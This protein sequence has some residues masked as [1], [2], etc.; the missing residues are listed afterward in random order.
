V[1]HSAAALLPALLLS[2]CALGPDYARPDIPVSATWRSPADSEASLGAIEWWQLFRD[3]ALQGLIRSA[4]DENKDVRLAVA[5]VLES[6]AQLGATRAAQFPQIDGKASYRNE[7]ASRVSFPPL[8]D[9]L[10]TEQEFFK[11]SLDLSFEIDLWGRLRRATEAARAELLASEEARRN[12]IVT[13]VSD[14]AQAYFT[15]LDLDRELEIARQTLVSRRESLR[16]VRLR[17]E[18][19]ITSELDLRRAEGEVAGASAQIPDLERQIAQSENRIS[20]LLGRNPGPVPRGASLT[21]QPLLPEV[22]AGLPSALLERRPDLRQAEH[23]LV[24]ANARIGEAK[25]AFFPQLMLTGAFGVESIALSDLFTG[26]AKIWQFGPRVTIPIFN[27]GR[28]SSNLRA[29]KARQ[30]QALIQYGQ[31]IQQAFREVEDALVTHRKLREIRPDREVLVASARRSLALAELRYKDGLAS[32]LDVLDA[33]R[34][35][36]AAEI[37]LTR[38]HR[39]QLTSVVQVYKALG[40]GWTPEASAAAAS[41]L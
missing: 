15:L 39:D 38:I 40:G 37:E 21:E 29:A 5:R 32:Y 33:Q 20:I 23:R 27:A 22:P 13:L 30:E 4:L 12:V 6:R 17:F 14:V 34:Q 2:G 24:A 8:P 9:K 16:I 28:L 7:R 35:L 25:A 31:T 1:R 36:F 3:D 26:P 18:N 19:G 11:S 41:E 10:D